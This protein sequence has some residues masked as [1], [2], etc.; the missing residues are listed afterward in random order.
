M[1][2]AFI[3]PRPWK[4]IITSLPRSARKVFEMTDKIVVLSTCS[5]LEEGERLARLL[6]EERLA[7]CVTVVPRA[8]SFYRWKGAV[9][10]ADECLMAIKSSR[11]LFAELGAA[12]GKAH[13]YELPEALA[14]P[15][16]DG[17]ANYLNWLGEN[18][19][20]EEDLA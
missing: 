8:R 4:I 20:A 10:A 14:I 6:V 15:V 18:L 3:V 13:S 19:R 7:A 9:E 5:N 2:S 12:L 1:R 16:L 17:S 11:G